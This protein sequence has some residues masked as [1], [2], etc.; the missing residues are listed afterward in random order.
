MRTE[1]VARLALLTGNGGFDAGRAYKAAS[2]LE[3][4]EES[5][6]REAAPG[7]SVVFAVAARK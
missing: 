1:P 2:A 7:Q 5:A 4:C 3:L 6:F